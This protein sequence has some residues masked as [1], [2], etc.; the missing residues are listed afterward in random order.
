MYIYKTLAT[1]YLQSSPICYGTIYLH[2]I[3][4]KITHLHMHAHS[5]HFSCSSSTSKL[6]RGWTGYAVCTWLGKY[7][8]I[9]YQYTQAYIHTDSNLRLQSTPQSWYCNPEQLYNEHVHYTHVASNVHVHVGV[10]VCVPLSLRQ[11]IVLSIS[12]CLSGDWDSST[13]TGGMVFSSIYFP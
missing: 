12:T 13:G 7:T 4:Y 1:I 5:L 11:E 9:H 8:H 2:P 10:S 3:P 6:C